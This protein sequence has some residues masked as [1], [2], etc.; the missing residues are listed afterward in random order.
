MS[1]S[2]LRRAPSAQDL[3]RSKFMFKLNH[4]MDW[5]EREKDS[6]PIV[7]HVVGNGREVIKKI[8]V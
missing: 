3:T 4:S 8:K 6:G 5:L 1:D 2:L 7:A